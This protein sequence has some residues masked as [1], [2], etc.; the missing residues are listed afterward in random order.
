M[1]SLSHRVEVLEALAA[2]SGG[3]QRCR[4]FW[5]VRLSEDAERPTVCPSCSRDLAGDAQGEPVV[6]EIR[7]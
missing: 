4:P 7:F 6:W 1:V 3:C 2:T 5:W